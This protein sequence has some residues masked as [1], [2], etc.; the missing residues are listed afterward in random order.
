ML[1]YSDSKQMQ[2]NQ[3]IKASLSKQLQSDKRKC[4]VVFRKGTYM[5]N[6]NIVN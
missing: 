4:K 2:F 6:G 5:I 1:I 3:Q